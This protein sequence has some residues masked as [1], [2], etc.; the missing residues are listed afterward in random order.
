MKSFPLPEE[1]KEFGKV[2]QE[3]GHHLYVVGGSIRDALLGVPNHD[4]DFTTDAIPQEVQRLFRRVIPT[5]IE[6]GTVTVLFHGQKYEV[7]TFRTEGAYLD[8]R[9]PSSVTFVPDLAEDLSRRDFTINAFAADCISGQII[10]LYH[11]REDLK[12]GVIRAIGEPRKRFQED[13][14]RILRALR[15]AAK[16]DFTIEPETFKAMGELKENL[17]HVSEERIHDELT[18]ML[19]SPHPAKGLAL[20]DQSGVLDVLLPDLANGRGIQQNGQHHD[21]VLAHCIHTCQIAADHGYSQYVR[22]AA[23]L[24]DIGKCR[25][26]EYHPDGNTYHHHDLV[27]AEITR[28]ILRNLKASNEEVDTVSHLV[29]QH[30]FTYTPE[31]SDAAVRRFIVRVGKDHL[32]DLFR[33]RICDVIATMTD[34]GEAENQ[35]IQ[36]AAYRSIQSLEQRIQSILEQG[37]ALSLKDLKINGN[38]VMALGVP[39]GPGV[40]E[41]LEYLLSCVMEDPAQNER[42]RLIALASAHLEASNEA[43]SKPS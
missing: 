25:T 29:S 5:G 30:M 11:G 34:Q 16:L 41:M 1:V 17:S 36:L 23:L 7:T 14:L 28:T 27:G 10:D 4:Y 32:D 39:K 13:A 38:D 21:T 35:T 3:H 43:T 24:H 12:D 40:K 26:V 9:H 6:H 2:F 31:W 37:D 22:E 20:A 42:D 8:M 18:K 33:L 15:F 19:C